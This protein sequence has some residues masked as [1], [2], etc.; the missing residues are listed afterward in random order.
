MRK[1]DFPEFNSAWA[2]ALGVYGVRQPESVILAVFAALAPYPLADVQRAIA[3]HISD[4]QNGKYAPKPADVIAWM[5]V[6]VQDG[7][8]GVEEAWAMCPLSERDSAW[9]TEEIAAAAAAASS[10]IERG[11]LIAGRMTFV[12]VYRREIQAARIGQRPVRWWR[13]HGWDPRTRET[14]MNQGL[15]QKY[16]AQAGLALPNLA[17]ATAE[18]AELGETAI[19]WRD[20]D[21]SARRQMVAELVAEAE[22]G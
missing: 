3:A 21:E 7:R 15:A 22:E 20:A 2:D 18:Q 4:P 8:P 14:P 9:M 1:E 19:A 6:S 13:S 12:E 17:P 11:D 16:L 10:L 5:L